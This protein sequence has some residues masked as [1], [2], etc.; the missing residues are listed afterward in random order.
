MKDE[1]AYVA[2]KECVGL[3]SRIYLFLVNDSNEHKKA[4]NVNKNAVATLSHCK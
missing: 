2:I 4:K 1:T 3:K